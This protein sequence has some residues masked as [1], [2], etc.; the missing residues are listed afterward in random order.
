MHSVCKGRQEEIGPNCSAP[1]SVIKGWRLTQYKEFFSTNGVGSL[2]DL[3]LEMPTEAAYKL[4]GHVIEGIWQ[5]SHR[6]PGPLDGVTM[7]FLV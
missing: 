4:I 7:A 5:R 6:K 2:D 3:S 1:S